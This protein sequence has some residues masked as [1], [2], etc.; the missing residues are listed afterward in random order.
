MHQSR[1]RISGLLSRLTGRTATASPGTYRSS[2]DTAAETL[3]H[4]DAR[5]LGIATGKPAP[6]S[7]SIDYYPRG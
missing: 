5:L 3:R 6:S 4:E 2:R 1:I 7:T